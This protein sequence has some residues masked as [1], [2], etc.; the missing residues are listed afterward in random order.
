MRVRKRLCVLTAGALLL[1]A[2]MGCGGAGTA[3]NAGEALIRDTSQLGKSTTY[4][5][6][7]IGPEDVSRTASLSMSPSCQMVKTIVTGNAEYRL[8][9]VCVSRNQHVE[10]GDTVAVLQGLGSAA[11]VEL[12]RLEIEAYESGVQEMLAW[13]QSAIDAAEALPQDT[14]RQRQSRSL[15]V[16]YAGL[17]YEKYRLQAD[18]TLS[19]MEDQLAALQAAAGEVELKSPVSGTVRSL[20]LRYEEGDVLPAGT[21]IC[22]VYGDAGM[23]LFGTSTSGV[24]VYGREV[25]F[26]CG[27]GKNEQIVTGRVISSPEV[28]SL[29]YNN[30][31]M[32]EVDASAVEFPDSEGSAETSF[33]VLTDVF[34]VPKSAITNRDGKSYVDVLI[35]DTVRTRSVVRGPMAGSMVAILHGL[36]AGDQVVVSSYNS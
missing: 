6:H 27:K 32:V 20:L 35:G 2:L 5:L 23:V 30:V 7:V 17:E 12:K 34:A 9:E 18:Y 11:D 22:R 33:T 15:Q 13:Y 14:E 31:V 10:A 29:P 25:T 24:F 16:E 3:A 21:E 19:A 28:V 26:R 8:K 36:H 4:N 1:T